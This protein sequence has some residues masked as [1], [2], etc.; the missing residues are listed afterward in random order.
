MRINT[1]YIFIFAIL[2]S[3]KLFATEFCSGW[4]HGY[5]TGYKKTATS[6]I[7]SPVPP[8]MGCPGDS[9]FRDFSEPESEYERGY[10]AG[11]QDGMINGLQTNE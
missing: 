11:L 8:L 1:F 4:E 5:K 10:I 2:F 9:F 7:F 6:S 3:T